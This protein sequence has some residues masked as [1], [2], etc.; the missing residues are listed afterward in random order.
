MRVGACKRPLVF[1]MPFRFDGQLANVL[2]G[3][4]RLEF[5]LRKEV[6]NEPA[7][8]PHHSLL[9]FLFQTTMDLKLPKL[10]NIFFHTHPILVQR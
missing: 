5:N 8:G 10:M 3:L 2:K 1:G 6:R 9:F 7:K 4:A